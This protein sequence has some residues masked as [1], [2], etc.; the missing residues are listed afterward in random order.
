MTCIITLLAILIPQY[1]IVYYRKV[2]DWNSNRFKFFWKL[3]YIFFTTRDMQITNSFQ[4]CFCKLAGTHI[5]YIYILGKFWCELC[6][7]YLLPLL[8]HLNPDLSYNYWLSNC[9]YTD[10]QYNIIYNHRLK[11]TI[12]RQ[13]QCNH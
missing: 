13:R 8:S 2:H 11:N 6:V 12:D 3:Q 5:V 7:D 1:F 4:N 10:I 9:F